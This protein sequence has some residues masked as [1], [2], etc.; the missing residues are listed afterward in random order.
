M[1]KNSI[2]TVVFLFCLGSMCAAYS[3]TSLEEKQTIQ[4]QVA[5][6]TPYII[7]LY[8]PTYIMPFSYVSSFSP[9]A[10]SDT[11]DNIGLDHIET[12]FQ[13][14]VKA[15]VWRNFFNYQN[16]LNLAYTQLSFWQVYNQSGFFR[17]SNY[18]PEIYFENTISHPIGLGWDLHFLNLGLIHDSNGRGGTYERS[19][20]RLYGEIT[21]SKTNWMASIRP[22]YVINNNS[23]ENNRDIADFLGYERVVIAYKFHQQTVSLLTY[24]LE[25]LGTRASFQGTYSFP[26]ISKFH[27]YVQVFSGY[28]QSLIDYNHYSNSA[29]LGIALN[30]WI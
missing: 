10:E 16:S 22:W 3:Q 12:K 13:F 11:P 30:D 26:I 18:Q 24:N 7:S 19:W 14:S 29:S 27:G 20:N 28:G 6:N 21:F 23:L 5:D 1:K 2:H 4:E 25:H 17:E 9:A 15:A 8:E